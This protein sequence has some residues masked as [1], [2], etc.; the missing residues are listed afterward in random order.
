MSELKSKT[1]RKKETFWLPEAENRV[2]RFW[3]KMVKNNKLSVI[4]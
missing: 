2:D 3:M 4:R 1:H